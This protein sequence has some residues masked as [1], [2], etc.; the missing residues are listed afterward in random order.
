MRDN[1]RMLGP[2][3]PTWAEFDERPTV[4]VELRS[5][6]A[7]LAEVL[8]RLRNDVDEAGRSGADRRTQGLLALAEQAILAIELETLLARCAEEDDDA[9]F[10][11]AHE[12]LRRLKDRMLTHIASAGLE[13]VRLGGARSCDVAELVEVDC[14]RYDDVCA[15]PEVVTEIEAAVLLDGILLRRGRVVMGGPLQE[16][17]DVAA[18]PRRQPPTERL[19]TG[20]HRGERSTG[21]PPEPRIVCPIAGC[22][23]E[24][25]AAAEA[26]V[27]CLTPLAAFARLSMHP[28]S[29][30]NAGLQAARSGD[31]VAARECFAAVVLWQPDELRARNAHALACLD[32]GDAQAARGAWEEVLARAPGDTLASRGLAA[33]S[34]ASHTH[35]R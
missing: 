4:D 24:N 16:H 6:A 19:A 31:V 29:L 17:A 9:A 27:G 33:L 10:E 21:R 14:W 30:F 12:A 20:D 25:H 26:C 3:Q 7:E 2:D 8:Q 13:V 1:S 23:A 5:P 35:Q 22:G 11:R 15:R 34:Y 32:A 28:E 18:P